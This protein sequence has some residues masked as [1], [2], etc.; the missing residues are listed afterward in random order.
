M[1]RELQNKIAAAHF[2]LMFKSFQYSTSASA[3][4]PSD[5]EYLK[6]PVNFMEKLPV[7][8]Y[9]KIQT[10]GNQTLKRPIFVELKKRGGKLFS[11]IHK[12]QQSKPF[13]AI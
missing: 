2:G 12:H 11:V 7:K 4:V 8:F 13:F 6:A 9:E 1:P 5:D 10:H 3:H